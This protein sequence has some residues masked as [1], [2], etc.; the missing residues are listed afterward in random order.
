MDGMEE[1]KRIIT[2]AIIFTSNEVNLTTIIIINAI[3][4][5]KYLYSI[6]RDYFFQL[7]AKQKREMT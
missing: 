1:T 3:E 4:H 7:T 2:F 5:Q 6:A